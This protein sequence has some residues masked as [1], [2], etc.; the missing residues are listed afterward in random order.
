MIAPYLPS[1]F[2]LCSSLLSTSSVYTSSDPCMSSTLAPVVNEMEI[3]DNEVEGVMLTTPTVGSEVHAATE[4]H[5]QNESVPI[6][7][8]EATLNNTLDV[9]ISD[10]MKIFEYERNKTMKLLDLNASRI[11][12]TT[13][14][15]TTSNQK[16]GFMA[17]TSH[18]IDVSWKLQ[19]RL[20]RLS[21][22]RHKWC[23]DLEQDAFSCYSMPLENEKAR[24]ELENGESSGSANVLVI[25]KAWQCY[26]F[27]T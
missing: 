8:N 16:R 17:I 1:K 19:S 21:H 15:W 7:A 6:E 26:V 14:M 18:F 13:D 9:E 27:C 23:H 20:V 24:N 25:P 4:S 5:S 3:N 2:D 12:L 22:M 10:I 11:A